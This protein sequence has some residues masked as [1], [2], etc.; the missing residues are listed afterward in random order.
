MDR[1]ILPFL[2]MS[3]T[4]ENGDIAILFI[5]CYLFEQVDT[6]LVPC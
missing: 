6:M 3:F 4:L 2:D 1:N 5:N